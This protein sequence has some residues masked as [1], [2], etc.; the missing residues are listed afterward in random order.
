M[1]DIT[2]DGTTVTV[3]G[4]D[5]EI[6][7]VFSHVKIE[8]ESYTSELEVDESTVDEGVTYE[9]LTDDQ[10]VT[11]AW[12]GGGSAKAS[13]VFNLEKEAKTTES[14][15]SQASAKIKGSLRLNMELELK[16]YISLSN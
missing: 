2:V 12:E 5:V 14:S 1:A 7:E 9:G 10:P 4:A 6:E 13:L 16:F 8:N 11:R 3:T 15:A